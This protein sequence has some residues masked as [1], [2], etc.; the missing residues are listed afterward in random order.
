MEDH[1]L[2]RQIYLHPRF[3]AL[4]RNNSMHDADLALL[5][6][7]ASSDRTLMVGELGR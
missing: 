5:V 4:D 2:G 3:N 1:P 6:V 7:T